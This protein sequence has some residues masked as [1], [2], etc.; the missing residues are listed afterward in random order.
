MIF[1]YICPTTGGRSCLDLCLATPN[2][3]T[4]I[5]IKLGTD[6]GSDHCTVEIEICLEPV[7][8]DTVGIL[9]FKKSG[10]SAEFEQFTRNMIRNKSVLD[11]P[12]A[13]NVMVNSLTD[14]I[15]NVATE[16]VPMTSGNRICKNTTPWW[17]A[18]CSRLVS[19]RRKVRKILE[20][21]PTKS[22][23]LDYNWKMAAA[24]EMCVKSKK[25]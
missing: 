6:V 4:Y 24:R 11:M 25:K 22:N 2:I 7:I 9:R 20:K 19:E 10:S 18:E 13:L 12:N 3:A 1:T 17:N 21:H 23:L 15:Y 16:S 5:D 14:R 8:T